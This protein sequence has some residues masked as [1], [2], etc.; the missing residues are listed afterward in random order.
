[1]SEVWFSNRRARLRK[2]SGSGS[3]ANALGFPTIPLGNMAC[4]YSSDPQYDWRNAQFH[5][6]NMF[7]QQSYN[8]EY[9]RA[10]Y[11]ALFDA[12]YALAQ[13]QISQV[14]ANNLSR[15]KD[16]ENYAI[17]HTQVSQVNGSSSHRVKDNESYTH[18]HQ[19]QANNLSRVKDDSK[20]Q[21]VSNEA[22]TSATISIPNNAWGKSGDWSQPMSMQDVG[23]SFSGTEPFIQGHY[24]ANNKNYWT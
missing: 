17:A 1:M 13:A 21:D 3:H 9:S 6:Y 14:Q 18:A 24:H 7:Q 2:N 4:Q 16:N 11:S 19:A 12:N 10:E 23:T 8:Q 15:I 5:N 20:E 22:S